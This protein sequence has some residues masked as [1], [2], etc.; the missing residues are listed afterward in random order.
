MKDF[1]DYLDFIFFIFSSG[2]NFRIIVLNK[3]NW[4]KIVE[5][6]FASL[7]LLRFSQRVIIQILFRLHFFQ[8]LICILFSLAD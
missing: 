1:G 2:K 8:F 5:K 7:S 4:K 3:K 6:N